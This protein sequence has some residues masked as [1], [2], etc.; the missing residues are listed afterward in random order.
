MSFYNEL[1]AHLDREQLKQPEPLE[2]SSKTFSTLSEALVTLELLG[3][4]EDRDVGVGKTGFR[5]EDGVRA[6]LP[7]RIGPVTVHFYEEVH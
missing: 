5:N 3:F 1:K 7:L 4:T 6:T 2:G